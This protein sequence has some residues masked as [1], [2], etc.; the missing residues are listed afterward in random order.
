MKIE[1]LPVVGCERLTPTVHAL[2]FRSEYIAQTIQAGQFINIKVQESV[3]PL[4]RRPFSVAYAQGNIATVIFDVVGEGTRILSRKKEGDT[5]D[6]LGPLGKPFTLPGADETALLVAGGL[7][8]APMPLLTKVLRERGVAGIETFLGA[9]SADWLVDYKMTN[10]HRATDDGTE[11]FHGTVVSLLDQW[12]EKSGGGR[13]RVYACGP[14]RMLRALQEQLDRRG[15]G[16]QVSLEC[17]MACGIGICQ[18]C[19]VESVDGEQR[20]R[21]VCREGPVFDIHSVKIS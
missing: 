1:I 19:P 6:V 21:L 18:G 14:N 12:L 15:M 17:V 11:G 5:I 3:F 10:V 16:G 20:Y 7:G 4:L 2:H 13:Y 8:M 9:R